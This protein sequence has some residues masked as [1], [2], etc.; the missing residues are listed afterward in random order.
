MTLIS[1]GRRVV[2]PRRA[3]S[4]YQGPPAKPKSNQKLVIRAP[5]VQLGIKKPATGTI[6][7]ETGR[8]V[9][10]RKEIKII[11]SDEAYRVRLEEIE[12]LQKFEFYQ[13]L[14]P[15]FIILLILFGY[16]FVYDFNHQPPA[17][18]VDKWTRDQAKSED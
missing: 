8:V 12:G 6:E 5:S 11:E 18:F 2:V 14:T 3:L 7:V 15:V 9:A 16:I 17:A 10:G 1:I 4:G 13:S